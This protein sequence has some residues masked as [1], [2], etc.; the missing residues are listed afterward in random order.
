M[1][2]ENRQL[3]KINENNLGNAARIIS[4]VLGASML[5]FTVVRTAQMTGM[6][7]NAPKMRTVRKFVNKSMVAP[8]TK[9]VTRRSMMS[10]RSRI[11][12]TLPINLPLA[13]FGG[14]LLFQGITGRAPVMQMLGLTPR[15]ANGKTG[16]DVI[17]SISIS[18]P[19][20][21]VYNFWRNF[22]NFPQF[23]NHV[24]AV[25]KLDPSGRRSHW[26][27]KAPAGQSVEWDA[28][29]IEEQPN[30][31]IAW[32]SLPGSTVD[33]QGSVRFNDSI[34]GDGTVVTVHMTYEPPAGQLGKV[35]AKLFG[36]EPSMQ[37][38]DDLNKL[39]Q[40]MEWRS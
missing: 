38:R 35:V 1:S 18:R 4:G 40:I 20:S 27:A 3:A 9:L 26:V 7:V 37:V 11:A 19:R 39:K 33:K 13:A 15:Q 2:I 28:E 17:S 23:M 6:R 12:K 29:I 32:R 21:E 22:E 25:Q 34:D 8:V 31:M 24:K 30:E 5:V 10:T 16:M 14:Y 36:E